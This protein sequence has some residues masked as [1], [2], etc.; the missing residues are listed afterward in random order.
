MF[1]QLEPV[2]PE[3]GGDRAHC[4][5]ISPIYN[6]IKGGEHFWGRKPT[7]QVFT[8]CNMS[9]MHIQVTYGA[10]PHTDTRMD[11]VYTSWK[12][13]ISISCKTKTADQRQLQRWLGTSWSTLIGRRESEFSFSLNT[14][15]ENILRLNSCHFGAFKRKVQLCMKI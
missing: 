9:L 6:K 13:L 14:K 8:C 12:Q 1:R 5:H 11:A 15:N 3:T 7:E 4:P 2:E 10:P